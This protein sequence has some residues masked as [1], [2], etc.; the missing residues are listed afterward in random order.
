M[1][2][3]TVVEDVKGRV[4]GLTN[5][6]QKVAKVSLN[7]LKQANGVVTDN[8]R[9][10]YRGNTDV[11]RDLLTSAK[12]GFEKARADGVKAVVAAPISYLPPRDRVLDA[13]KDSRSI[14][15]RTS[16]DL[17]KLVK[18]GIAA[19][20]GDTDDVVVEAKKTVRKSRSTA[21]KTVKKATRTV[22]AAT[23]S[24]GPSRRSR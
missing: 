21:R 2:L 19:V 9:S 24:A 6:G 23:K 11:V 20:N 4:E 12:S 5:Q 17:V 10:L 8:V 22:K 15:V 7:T 13:F 14:V 18:E 3:Q 1:N 16:D